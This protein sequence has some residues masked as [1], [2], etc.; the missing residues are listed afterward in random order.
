MHE[1]CRRKG[2]GK[3]AMAMARMPT[4]IKS[5]ENYKFPLC[6]FNWCGSGCRDEGS[7]SRLG[8]L[9]TCCQIHTTRHSA[10]GTR[11]QMQI[12]CTNIVMVRETALWFICHNFMQIRQIVRLTCNL[13][14][15]RCK[16]RQRT[17]LAPHLPPPI[18]RPAIC[19]TSIPSHPHWG[20]RHALN[21]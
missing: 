7:F 20:S 19:I 10:V 1:L 18:R 17:A 9:A 4:M 2:K 8:S 21:E 15:F 16:C 11:P 5:D 3:R 6:R 14:R 12:A 13:M